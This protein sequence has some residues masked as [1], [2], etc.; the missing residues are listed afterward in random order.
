M[1]YS[2]RLKSLSSQYCTLYICSQSKPTYAHAEELK[3]AQRVAAVSASLLERTVSNR[4]CLNVKRARGDAEE[5]TYLLS[6]SDHVKH[7]SKGHH[8]LLLPLVRM[9]FHVV[10]LRAFFFILH[11]L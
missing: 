4:Q 6:T 8:Y 9:D 1:A 7:K 3:N 5:K 11:S 2:E 10:H